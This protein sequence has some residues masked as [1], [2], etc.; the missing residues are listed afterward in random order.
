MIY[1]L[2][3]NNTGT[4]YFQCC[5]TGS[6]SFQMEKTQA[7]AFEELFREHSIAI[8][9]L[10]Y[11]K[12]ADEQYALINCEYK[13]KKRKRKVRPEDA[14]DRNHVIR[15]LHEAG[16]PFFNP[17]SDNYFQPSNP[18][19]DMYNHVCC[20]NLINTYICMNI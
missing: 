2:R 6:R 16:G 3:S 10:Q 5:L 14:H 17:F 11:P 4:V 9:T 20:Q 7:T 8:E 13:R 19:I 1:K 12:E 15:E 18:I